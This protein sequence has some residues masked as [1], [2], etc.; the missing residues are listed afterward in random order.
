MRLVQED[1]NG[2]GFYSVPESY[3][4]HLIDTY[5]DKIQFNKSE[6]G[7]SQSSSITFADDATRLQFESDPV[8]IEHRQ[9][10]EAYNQANGIVTRK[11]LDL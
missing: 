8:V 5:G 7:S 2:A 1:P 10:R 9:L 6:N 4:A 3:I 11:F